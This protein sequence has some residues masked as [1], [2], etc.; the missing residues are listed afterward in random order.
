M[1][2]LGDYVWEE[3]RREESQLTLDR[4]LGD[5]LGHWAAG[6]ARLG[7]WR[8]WGHES[9]PSAGMFHPLW[10]TPVEMASWGL[11]FKFRRKS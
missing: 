3:K 5:W 4:N 8:Q 2:R 10:D 11:I 7:V 6:R 1:A 9:Q